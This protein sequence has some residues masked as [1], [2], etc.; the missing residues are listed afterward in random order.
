M[1]AAVPLEPVCQPTRFRDIP[2]LR[3]NTLKLVSRANKSGAAA[4]FI[5]LN[6][7]LLH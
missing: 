1:T 6:N 2:S 5:M 3:N 7:R 4:C